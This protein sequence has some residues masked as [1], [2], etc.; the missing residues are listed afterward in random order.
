MS[1]LYP[2]AISAKDALNTPDHAALTRFEAQNLA[3]LTP[4]I[5]LVTEWLTMSVQ[6][7]AEARAAA[8]TGCGVGFVQYYENA[9]GEAVLAVTYWQLADPN[10]G[11]IGPE[12]DSQDEEPVSLPHEDDHTDDLYFR[13]GRTRKR[14]PRKAVDPNQMDLFGNALKD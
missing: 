5:G 1:H 2:L 9:A 8:E 13:S 3:G 4:L 11:L 6:K 12:P 7:G 14:G 10:A